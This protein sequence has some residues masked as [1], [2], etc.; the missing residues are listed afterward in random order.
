M[1]Y[2]VALAGIGIAS[3]AES[4][5]SEDADLAYGFAAGTVERESGVRVRGIARTETLVDLAATASRRALEAARRTPSEIDC[6][7]VANA[8]PHQPIP[9]TAV[10]LKRALNFGAS[11]VPAFDV[12][13]T[14]LGF[15]VALDTAA[16]FL[17][18]GRYGR[19]LI[20]A[21]DL[22]SRGV[23]WR[24]PKV[25]GI[26]GDGAAAI[27]LERTRA[28]N[29]GILDLALETYADAADACVVRAGGTAI[30]PH[31]DTEAFLRGARFE[32]DGPVAYRVSADHLPALVERVLAR[33]GVT[34]ADVDVIVPHQ[35]SVT[36]LALME[37]RLKIP[38][39]RMIKIVRDRGNQV[40]ASLPTALAWAKS[41]G[42]IHDGSLVMLLGTA[43]GITL[44]VA[45]WRL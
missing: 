22:P 34:M 9:A 29:R 21:A 41:E 6:I 24:D 14:C 35:A 20:A 28:S 27:V 26:F 23:D 45:L 2:R 32:M 31:T 11:A 3:P 4:L 12:N 7:I 19:I 42:R 8:V 43:A 40:A 25:A 38:N 44:G 13:A 37:R 10:L 33:A 16:A 1:L 17:A 39:G 18:T 36:A 30:D 15:L 5:R